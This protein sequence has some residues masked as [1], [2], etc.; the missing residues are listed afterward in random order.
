MFTILFPLSAYVAKVYFPALLNLGRMISAFPVYG[1]WIDVSLPVQASYE[2]IYLLQI[3]YPPTPSHN[4]CYLKHTGMT[5]KAHVK[6][7]GASA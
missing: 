7:D 2:E 3:L 4:I 5:M 6:N 1:M